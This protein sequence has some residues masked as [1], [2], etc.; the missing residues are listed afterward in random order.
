MRRDVMERRSVTSYL[1]LLL[2]LVTLLLRALNLALEMLSLDVDLTQSR[3]DQQQI[4]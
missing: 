1:V 2:P 3:R 4:S